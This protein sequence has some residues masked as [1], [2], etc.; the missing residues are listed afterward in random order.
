MTPKASIV[1]VLC[2]ITAAAAAS[3]TVASILLR[4]QKSH[5]KHGDDLDEAT[6]KMKEMKA[7]GKSP[8]MASTG[9]TD[10]SQVKQIV[11]ACDAG[12]GSS[13]MGASMLRKKVTE[14]GLPRNNFV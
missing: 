12:M 13:A 4:T 1:G 7:P 3:F 10:L 5:P 8:A 2:A 14:A 11:V 9:T 6:R